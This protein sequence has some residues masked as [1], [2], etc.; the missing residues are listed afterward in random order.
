MKCVPPFFTQVSVSWI[1]ASSAVMELFERDFG[2]HVQSCQLHVGVLVSDA[3]LQGPH[4][5]LGLHSLRSYDIGYFKVERDILS[6][7]S[8]SMHPSL[9]YDIRRHCGCCLTSSKRWPAP[10][11]RPTRS[12]RTRT[13]LPWQR[14]V[15]AVLRLWVRDGPRAV[16]VASA[17]NLG[18]WIRRPGKL[19]RM[20]RARR[21][22][23]QHRFQGCLYIVLRHACAR[24]CRHGP[25]PRQRACRG[26]PVEVPIRRSSSCLGLHRE[27]N[28]RR[29]TH[30]IQLA[31]C[32]RTTRRSCPN[33]Q[34]FLCGQ[35]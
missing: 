32:M 13:S 8:V 34:V 26:T 3:L 4:R 16:F 10:L 2:A 33:V 24:N 14:Y 9:R 20:K 18:C 35:L 22:S 1:H 5:F 25:G 28:D 19:S 29:S 30:S 7:A 31:M 15:Y 12:W 6:E 11:A 17:Y 27:R 21:L 23:R